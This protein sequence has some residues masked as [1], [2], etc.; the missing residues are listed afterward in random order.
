MHFFSKRFFC[1]VLAVLAVLN[2]RALEVKCL[3][4]EATRNPIG[5]DIEQPHFSWVLE[6]KE[7]GV[8]QTSY[9]VQIATD[10]DFGSIVWESGT[11]NTNQ[12]AHVTP[13]GFTLQPRTRYFWRVTVTDNKGNTATSAE[14]AY[15][16]TG[17][18]KASAWGAAQWIKA[19][20]LPQDGVESPKDYEIE[21][22]FQIKSVA[23]GFIFAAADHNNYYMWQF[24]LSGNTAKFRP[25]RWTGGSASCLEEKTLSAGTLVQGQNHRLRIV[26]KNASRAYTYLDGT[27]IDTRTGNFTYGELGF[28]QFGNPTPEE[29]YFDNLRV[30]ANQRII[31]SEDFQ[32]QTCIFSNGTITG[33]RFYAAGPSKYCWQK[34]VAKTVRYDVDVDITLIRDNA[35]VCF[36]ATSQNTF[37]M[38][39]LNTYN[40]ETA[41]LRRH[42]YQKGSLTYSDVP[43]PLEISNTLN[44]QHHLRME[45]ET[46]Y[47]RTYLDGV[48][49]DTY[50]DTQGI[51]ALG[52]VGFRVSSVNE[53]TELAYFDNIKV[54]TFDAEGRANVVLSDDFEGRACMFQDAVIRD[55]QGSKQLYM[56]ARGGYTKRIM[57]ADGSVLPGL[58]ILR[59]KFTLKAPVRQARLYATALGIYNAFIN[60]TRVGQENDGNFVQDELKPGST[61]F[62]KT[63]FYVTH[64]V[65]NLLREG[66]N[67][68]GVALSSGWWSGRITHGVFGNKEMAFKGMLV[69]CYEDG[70]EE[71]ICSDTS[72]TSNWNGPWRNGDIYDGEY[73]DAR[74]ENGWATPEYDAA[75]W[76]ATAQSSDFKGEIR[77]YEGPQVLAVERLARHPQRISIYDGTDQTS[78]NYGSLHLTQQVNGDQTISLKAGETA[79]YDMGQNAA[80][81]V[82]FVAKGAR[83]TRL[84]FRFSEMCNETGSTGRG[85]DGPAGSLYLENLRSAQASLHY[86]LAGK[87][88]GEAFHPTTTF[89]GFR[90]VEVTTSA[91]VELSQVVGETVTS[92]MEENSSFSTSH[93]DVN[94]LYSNIMWSERS[95]FLSVPTD[96]PQRDERLGWAGDTNVFSMAGLYNAKSSTF[97]KKW[98]RDMRDSQRSDG[99]FPHVAPYLWD[100]GFGGG[101]WADAGII[102][103]Y[104]V[105]LMTGDKTVLADNFAAMEKYMNWLTTQAA[106]GFKFNGP[107]TRY[108]DWVS[109]VHTEARYISVCYYAYDADLMARMA[110]AL[111]TSE[112]DAYAQKAAKYDKL[113]ADIRA[114]WQTR[115]L[116]TTTGVPTEATQCAYLL[117]LRFDMLPDATMKSRT[118]SAL[119]NALTGNSHKL[120]TG[121]VGTSVLNQTLTDVGLTDDAYC[122]LLQRECPS[123]LYSVDQGATTIWERW[124]SYTK[125]SG[126]NRNVGM[127]SFNHYSYGAVAEWMYRHMAGIA[128]CDSA[129]GF[130]HFVLRPNPDTRNILRYN[131]KR[132]TWVD[133]D[134][135]SQYGHIRAKWQTNG[136]L[137]ATKY[138]VTVPANTTATLYLPCPNG[139]ELKESGE[140]AAKA[141]GVE[142]MGEEDGCQVYSLGS[143]SYV[144]SF[145][146]PTSVQHIETPKGE[147]P[148]YT[149]GGIRLSDEKD[150]RRGIVI[151]G[152]KKILK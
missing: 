37:L 57:Q 46:P 82:S 71:T 115:F 106:D 136:R 98:L 55:Y 75:D 70:T 64:D 21:I 36:S 129:P 104:N 31:L 144:F 127:N 143:G 25:H 152:R 22:T 119:H 133:A 6:S 101:V 3:R 8:M 66:E 14:K 132:I 109:F 18:M 11:Q 29:A 97:Y 114:E 123:W 50:E 60:G 111:S 48:L 149:V 40:V 78:T 124:D 1:A 116:N 94:Q 112:N 20:E 30:T 148:I 28:R 23:A 76:F 67:A 49:V 103:P 95:N 110:R 35:S 102:V 89:Y 146:A 108:G 19:T 88:E 77:A 142:Y 41:T 84:R 12:S 58:P 72:W 15:F 131:Q 33:G 32:G 130:Q 61:D 128:P 45:C 63:A 34:A 140:P 147:K 118:V 56:A 122:L 69:V 73:Y 43:L 92:A 54:T 141:E 135:D 39:A 99:A 80:G 74:L 96:C 117:A 83:G 90:Y 100:V 26:V 105:Y 17:L 138:E 87:S 65:T 121:F 120:N 44:H 2:A 93:S 51:L 13:Q 81:W 47:V 68:I 86:T 9:V 145:G 113:A 91:D 151:S 52:D 137:A 5:I 59:R 85:E 24:N 126:F 53:T 134:Y 10:A 4:T 38:W 62:N 125:N 139:Y 16:E 150:V 79:I 107:T 42:A 7:R 27:I